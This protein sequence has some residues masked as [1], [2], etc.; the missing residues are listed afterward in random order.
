MILTDTA[1]VIAMGSGRIIPGISARSKPFLEELSGETEQN[2]SRKTDQITQGEK[3]MVHL[4]P[5]E[6][7]HLH[8]PLTELL[9]LD[10]QI[11]AAVVAMRPLNQAHVQQLVGSDMAHWPEILVVRCDAGYLVVDGN[12]RWQAA[13]IKQVETIQ[14][15]VQSFP[16]EQA[17]IDAAFRSNLI[18]GLQ[19][20]PSTRGAY[21]CWLHTTFPTLS[22]EKLA[23][24]TG[25]TQGAVSK[26]LAKQV[27]RLQ[28]AGTPDASQASGKQAVRRFLAGALRFLSEVEP[29]SD[30][31]LL[32]LLPSEDRAKMGRL[33]RLLGPAPVGA[34][35]LRLRQFLPP[36][37]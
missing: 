2:S 26:A 11:E 3:T 19:A 28:E 30:E 32:A 25:L 23:R 15:H 9:R 31:E 20:S 16:D 35:S 17:V 27:A 37:D 1:P 7:E 8:L 34:G 29:L 24:L 5:P 10:E 6:Q 14:A 22:Q 33:A 13:Q 4:L 36:H 12:H 18:H 21:A